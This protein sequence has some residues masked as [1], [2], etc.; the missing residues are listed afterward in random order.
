METIRQ[1]RKKSTQTYRDEPNDTLMTKKWLP[2]GEWEDK[3]EKENIT[4]FAG[5]GFPFTEDE[6]SMSDN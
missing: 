4:N 2:N 5:R 1:K 3:I 6:T